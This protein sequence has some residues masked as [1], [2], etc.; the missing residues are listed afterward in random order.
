MTGRLATRTLLRRPRAT[1]LNH[2]S[3]R[4]S[5][6][7]DRNGR[8][9]GAS[10]PDLRTNGEPSPITCEAALLANFI[11]AVLYAA[12]KHSTRITES[13]R[14]LVLAW[15]RYS[16]N[17]IE[18]DRQRER[19]ASAECVFSAPWNDCRSYVPVS[20]IVARINCTP[21]RAA[22]R[23][24]AHAK[25]SGKHD[26]VERA[27]CQHSAPAICATCCEA[28]DCRGRTFQPA[29]SAEA[30]GLQPAPRPVARGLAE[31]AGSGR[32]AGEHQHIDTEGGEEAR[33][34][35]AKHISCRRHTSASRT[36]R[37]APS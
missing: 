34:A 28:A 35:A 6:F 1:V 15:R 20:S 23:R 27:S 2:R 3:R 5:R 7:H 31:H 25:K 11:A 33:T 21:A 9:C 18:T 22:H 10:K 37:T 30:D 8:H 36:P 29:S 4:S 19:S 26:P 14:T 17:E 16:L 12:I 13:Y 32:T 24:T